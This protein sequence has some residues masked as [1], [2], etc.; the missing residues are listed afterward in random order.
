MVEEHYTQGAAH[1]LQPNM[2]TQAAFPAN[3]LT[4]A[5]LQSN[6]ELPHSEGGAV[7]EE[8]AQMVFDAFWQGHQKGAEGYCADHDRE[9]A[10]KA[11]SIDSIPLQDEQKRQLMLSWYNAGLASGSSMS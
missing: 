8:L 1:M 5:P 3:N 9:L 10:L 2:H 6:L 7:K 11:L 4:T